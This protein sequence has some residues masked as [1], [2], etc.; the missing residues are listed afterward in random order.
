MSTQSMKILVACEFSGT[1]R[2]AF[3]RRG[4]SAWSCDIESPSPS[5]YSKYHYRYDVRRL[6][7]NASWDM[8]IAHPP[9]TYLTN[10]GVRHLH[11]NVSS[12]NGVK[13]K[14]NGEERWKLMLEACEFFQLFQNVDCPRVCIENPIPHGYAR[15][16]IGYY[17]QKVQPWMFGHT[18]SK[19]ICLWLKGLPK[20][21]ETD[22]VHQE[23]MKLPKKERNRIHYMSPGKDRGKL[24]S[25]F[26]AGIAKAMA[27][28][29]GG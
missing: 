13:A 7:E 15:E 24:R 12:R 18:E 16:R 11:S 23:M 8:I 17:D 19:A 9:C 26:Y 5:P 1:V 20:L 10:A 21:V 25:I 4:H 28:Q 2:D 22:N 29:W 6:L 27:E 14:I 3:R